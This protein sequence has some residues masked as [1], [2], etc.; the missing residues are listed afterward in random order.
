MKHG[1]QQIYRYNKVQLLLLC[2]Q[3]LKEDSGM[4]A[5]NSEEDD[6]D[7]DCES[8]EQDFEANSSKL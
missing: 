5:S 6:D 4:P 8:F 1:G 7:M 3:L 2:L